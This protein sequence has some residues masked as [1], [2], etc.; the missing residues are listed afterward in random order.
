MDS[1]Y[2]KGEKHMRRICV[3]LAAT[4]FVAAVASPTFAK[5]ET[6]AG[7][8]VDD[9]C[10]LENKANTTQKHAMKNGPVETC[11]TSCAKKGKPVALVTKDGRKYVVVGQYT[12]NKNQNLIAHMTH[13]V[14][15]TG[16][17]TSARD[18]SMTIAVI[19]IRD[20]Q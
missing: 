5:M 14:E 8:L 3:G 9:E 18:G 12:A 17:V 15:L 20:T 13:S 4:A 16:N 10:Y 2:P 1:R 11:A 6:V 19:S 7:V